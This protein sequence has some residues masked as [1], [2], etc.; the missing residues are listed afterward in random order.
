MGLEV[1][2]L[3]AGCCGMAGGWGYE[4]GHYHVS[5]A[6]GERVLLPK[7]RDADPETVIVAGGFSCRSQIEQTGTGR[8]AL[9]PAQVLSLARAG[10]GAGPYPERAVP[11]RPAPSLGRR[12]RRAAA[13]AAVSSLAGGALLAASR[14]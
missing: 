11:R 3:E 9:H 5:I 2:E 7:V 12:A 6:C 13:V 14:R 10:A 4:T 8:S 1:E